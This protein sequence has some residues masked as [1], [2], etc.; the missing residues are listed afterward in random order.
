MK[1]MLGRAGVR[2]A[3]A[4]TAMHVTRA[5]TIVVNFIAV[6]VRTGFKTFFWEGEAPAEPPRASKGSAGASPS[7]VI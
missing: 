4:D 6:M 7:Q 5:I 3:H 1:T 2:D